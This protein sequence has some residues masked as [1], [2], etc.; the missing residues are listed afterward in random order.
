MQL[1]ATIQ[2]KMRVLPRTSDEKILAI[3]QKR[4]VVD[5]KSVFCQYGTGRRSL[6]I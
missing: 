1:I 6:R 5:R 3:G 4:A 2:V